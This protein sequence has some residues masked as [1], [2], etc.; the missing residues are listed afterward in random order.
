[1][2]CDVSVW[3]E[4]NPSFKNGVLS[5]ECKVRYF[6]TYYMQIALKYILIYSFFVY[7]Q[8][9]C[10]HHV[11]SHVLKMRKGKKLRSLTKEVIKNL[12]WHKRTQD[13]L[14]WTSDATGVSCTSIKKL[15]NEKVGI[16]GAAIST[17]TRD[18]D[19]PDAFYLMILIVKPSDENLPP[20]SGQRACDT[21]QVACCLKGNVKLLIKE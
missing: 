7:V 17:P 3:V 20:L 18:T 19:C 5:I 10:T 4:K 2:Q 15:W 13:L 6:H 11:F 16:N 9:I 1:M 8:V 12:K 21:W 14:K